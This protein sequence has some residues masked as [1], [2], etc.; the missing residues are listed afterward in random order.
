MEPIIDPLLI[1]SHISSNLIM[2]LSGF[3]RFETSEIR[4]KWKI[5]TVHEIS[6][7]FFDIREESRMLARETEETYGAYFFKRK[8]IWK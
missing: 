5:G 2:F 6:D 7:E 1:E 8:N 3:G 4:L